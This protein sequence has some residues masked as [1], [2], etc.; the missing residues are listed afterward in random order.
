MYHVSIENGNIDWNKVES[1]EQCGY[2]QDDIT[3]G[4]MTV[5]ENVQTL[6]EVNEIIDIV[7]NDAIDIHVWTLVDRPLRKEVE[8]LLK[9]NCKNLL[10]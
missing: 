5:L 4:C 8:V 1:I 6:K 10:G 9:R 7:K 3:N 2:C